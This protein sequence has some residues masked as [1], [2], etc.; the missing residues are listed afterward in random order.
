[1]YVKD[2]TGKIKAMTVQ[3][4][5]KNANKVQ[6]L[7]VSE[8]LNERERNPLLIGQNS[9]FDVANNSIGMSKI[10]DYAK[11]IIASLGTE[12]QTSEKVYDKEVAMGAMRQ[13]QE[14]IGA[15]RVPTAEERK[16]FAVLDAIAGSPARYNEVKQKSSSQKNHAMK[17]VNYIWSTLE[18]GA[19]NKLSAQA[20]LNNQEPTQLLLDLVL[21][22]TNQSE[23]TSLKPISEGKAK[24]G[25]ETG[26]SLSGGKHMNN[27]QMMIHGTLATGKEFQFNDPEAST[28]F[29]GLILGTSALTT[30][31]GQSLPPTTLRAVMKSGWEQVIDTNNVFF[32]N[33]KVP[34]AQFSEIVVDGSSDMGNVYLPVDPETGGPDNKSLEMFRQLMDHYNSVKDNPDV[35]DKD[36]EVMFNNSGFKVTIN[37]DKTLDV[38]ATGG[39]VK[40][41]FITWAYTNNATNLIKGND[42]AKRGGLTKLTSDEHHAM[43]PVTNAA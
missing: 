8:L 37:P 31:D 18:S 24:T 36:L 27:P 38:R 43:V 19:K 20:A 35:S 41:F 10:T 3:A 2:E 15:G 25:Q 13:L 9:I 22:S 16:G 23:E 30:P 5:K 1:M 4:Y 17:A 14:E 33:R 26:E 21:M 12:S 40:P 7:T 28:K 42:D 39:N 6:T 34:S 29:S 11:K 32:G